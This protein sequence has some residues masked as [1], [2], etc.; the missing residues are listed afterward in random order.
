MSSRTPFTAYKGITCV[1]TVQLV[2]SDGANLVDKYDGTESLAATAWPGDDQAQAFALTAAWNDA[3]LGLVDLTVPGANTDDQSDGLYQWLIKL[4]NDAAVLARG[5]MVLSGTPGTGFPGDPDLTS[6]QYL[7]LA[8]SAITLTQAQTDYLPYAVQAASNMTRSFCNRD[9]NRQTY[10]EYHPPSLEGLILLGQAPVNSLTRVSAN[11][12]IAVTVTASESAFQIA[13]LSFTSTGDY[14][15]SDTAQVYTGI[16]LTSVASGVTTTTAITFAANPTISQLVSAINAVSGWTATLNSSSYGAWPTSE[17]YCQ[18][19][20][21]G[22][23][24]GNGVFLQVFSQDISARV[25]HRTGMIALGPGYSTTG[26]G[27]KWGP[28]WLAF[29]TPAYWPN[30]NTI[31]RVVYDAGYDVIPP[32]VQQSVADITK[33]ILLRFLSDYTL[34]KESIGAYSYELRDIWD[35]IPVSARQSLSLYRITNA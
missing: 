11:L 9:F 34:K 15:G 22:A 13:Y 6:L 33:V 17:I 24:G 26:F 35:A 28:D 20:G 7:Q 8:L 4:S 32:L 25:D 3:A 2:D 14:S 5:T 12:D 18:D 31:V 10:T 29:D 21:Q 19:G 27:P 23:I 30:F 1:V 16:Q